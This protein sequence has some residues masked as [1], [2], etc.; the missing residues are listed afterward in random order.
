MVEQTAPRRTR[1]VQAGPRSQA[2]IEA[3]R[4]ATLG[5]LDRVGFA[6][7]TMD[8]V[9][10]IAGIN[11]KTAVAYDHLLSNLFVLDA[12]PAWTSNRLA[13]LVRSSKRF[14]ADPSLVAAALVLDVATVMRDGDLLG[15]L[16]E[17]FVLAQIRPEAQLGPGG[18]R[19]H[20]LRDRDGRREVDLVAELP[21]GD[22][23]AI[24]VKATAT[25]SSSDA[26]H[27]EWL[28]DELGERFRA[29]AVLHTGLDR[30]RALQAELPPPP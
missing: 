13:R 2:V 25:P 20:H 19:L 4:A 9:A 23:V 5:E 27:L 24:E 14:L 6:A 30:V 22:L 10:R 28:R 18:P 21:G 11:R 15:R 17:T 8:G 29:G 12:L 3:V 16:I 1:N 26:R 7:M